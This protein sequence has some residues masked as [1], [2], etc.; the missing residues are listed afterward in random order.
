[1]IGKRYAALEGLLLD[2]EQR[3]KSVQV[4]WVDREGPHVGNW[5]DFNR[6]IFNQYGPYG[7]RP[8]V[9]NLLEFNMDQLDAL[10]EAQQMAFGVFLH[11][12]GFPAMELK[13]NIW[14]NRHGLVISEGE[15]DEV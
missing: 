6:F 8:E 7:E 5:H 14:E 15:K 3:L 11:G 4:R 12:I 1:M 2:L 10:N 13:G 9:C